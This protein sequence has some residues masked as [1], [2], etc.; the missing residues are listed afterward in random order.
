MYHKVIHCTGLIKGIGLRT[1]E[2]GIVESEEYSEN[3]IYSLC[4]MY[5]HLQ[6]GGLGALLKYNSGTVEDLNR[7]EDTL[8][9]G[10]KK[11]VFAVGFRNDFGGSLY[12]VGKGFVYFKDS[13]TYE[14]ARDVLELALRTA[15]SADPMISTRSHQLLTTK[16]NRKG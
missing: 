9:I 6:Y 5:K 12:K 1:A 15:T 16:M 7:M 2:H 4:A 8:N 14:V 11:I 3:R 10:L 13:Y